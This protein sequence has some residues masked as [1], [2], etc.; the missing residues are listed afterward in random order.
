VSTR[1]GARLASALGLALGM[2]L[3]LG[4][5]TDPGCIR[6]SECGHGYMCLRAMCVVEPPDGA[7][8]E[9]ELPYDEEDAG[10]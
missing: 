8:V 3:V 7:V 5:C 2:A 9:P 10:F 1:S 6:H 4:S